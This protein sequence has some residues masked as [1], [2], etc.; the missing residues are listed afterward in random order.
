MERKFKIS[1]F[2]KRELVGDDHGR[3]STF[4]TDMG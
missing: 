1:A 2:A 3:N 4:G